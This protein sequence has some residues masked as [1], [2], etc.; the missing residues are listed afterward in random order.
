MPDGLRLTVHDHGDVVPEIMYGP[1]ALPAERRGSGYGWPLV[2]RLARQITVARRPGGGKT[3]S[4][5][6]PL[7]AVE[8]SAPEAGQ[9][10]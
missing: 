10:A 1:G 9:P 8:H 5:L 7:R 4:V 2:V 6:I 3:I